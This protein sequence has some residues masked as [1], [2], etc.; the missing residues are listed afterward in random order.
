M[1]ASRSCDLSALCIND[2]LGASDAAE[3]L[4]FTLELH[5]LWWRCLWSIKQWSDGLGMHGQRE[6]QHLKDAVGVY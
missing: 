5:H 6:L 4:D 1:G 2:G 3:R